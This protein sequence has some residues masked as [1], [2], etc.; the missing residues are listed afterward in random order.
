MAT[1]LLAFVA[2][3]LAFASWIQPHLIAPAHQTLALDPTSMGFGQNNNGPWQLFPAS[4]N[5]PN[6][7][8]YSTH[9]VDNAGH[10]LASQLLTNTC[11]TLVSG[12][13]AAAPS[14]AVNRPERIPAPAGAQEALRDCVVKISATYHELVTY[15]P[16][17]RYWAFQCYEAA[18]FV[19]AALALTGLCFWWVRRRLRASDR[20]AGNVSPRSSERTAPVRRCGHMTSA[21]SADCPIT[22]RAATA[23]ADETDTSKTLRTNRRIVRAGVTVRVGDTPGVL[24]SGDSSGGH[25][26]RLVVSGTVGVML[27]AP[28]YEGP[29]II[30]IAGPPDDQLVPV[31][32]QRRRLAAML[33]DL[34]ED[35]WRSGSRCDAWTV[36]DVVSHLVGVNVFWRASVLA[37][38]HR[39]ADPRAGRVRSRDNAGVAGRPHAGT[40]SDRGARPVHRGRTR[41]S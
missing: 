41:R 34:R 39:H 23:S 18:V 27:V 28:R 1:T 26:G 25:A 32:R 6:A 30:S 7:W 10:L 31:V 22:V 36:Q 15:Q 29:P 20:T 4:P 33:V 37:G 16:A 35:D 40:D 9:I 12:P 8:T 24:P 17:N 11:P 13:A 5:L 14:P 2:A 3:R 38:L 19:G 21:N